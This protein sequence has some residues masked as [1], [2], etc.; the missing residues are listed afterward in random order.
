MENNIQYEVGDIV[1]MKKAHP[2]G[3]DQWKIIRV[4]M[5]YKL[6]CLNCDRLI[7]IPYRKFIK[8]VKRRV[9]SD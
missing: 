6:K 1:I 3:C 8:G 4:G 2:C 5:D 9:T 7:M